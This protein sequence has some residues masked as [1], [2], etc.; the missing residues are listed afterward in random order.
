MILKELES[1]VPALTKEELLTL[2]AN[3]CKDGCLDSIRVGMPLNAI[4]DGHNRYTICEANGIQYSTVEIGGIHTVEDAKAWMI[5]NQFGRR[6]ATKQL[7]SRLRGDLYN[8]HKCKQGGNRGNQ[9]TVAN[10]QNVHLPNIAEELA[11][12]HGVSEKTIRRDGEYAEALLKVAQWKADAVSLADAGELRRQQIV[13][14]AECPLDD[15]DAILS[16]AKLA[17][18][19]IERNR[20]VAG[21]SE[22][23]GEKVAGEASF[24]LEAEPHQADRMEVPVQPK[25]SPKPQHIMPESPPSLMEELSKSLYRFEDSLRATMAKIPIIDQSTAREA[26]YKHLGRICAGF[27]P[28]RGEVTQKTAQEPEEAPQQEPTIEEKAERLLGMYE[29][30]LAGDP[31]AKGAVERLSSAVLAEVKNLYHQKSATAI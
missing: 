9:Y 20:R 27:A 31:R 3:I 16:G 30:S 10:G 21:E 8:M 7:Q 5:E 17:D 12:A 13:D 25:P 26:V 19:L 1:Y 15:R 18:I 4:I 2:E 23:A 29:S 28:P 22:P 11:E 24:T 14:L 6:N